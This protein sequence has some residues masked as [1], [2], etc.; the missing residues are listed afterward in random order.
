[1][2]EKN[3]FYVLHH[4][5]PIASLSADRPGLIA[6][7]YLNIGKGKVESLRFILIFIHLILIVRSGLPG[8]AQRSTLFR[9]EGLQ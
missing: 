1:M 5:I 7:G 9:T 8:R 6:E 2:G 4:T 3:H